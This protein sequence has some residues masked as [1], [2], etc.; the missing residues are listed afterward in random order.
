VGLIIAG[1]PLSGNEQPW[2]LH[3][4]TTE[5]G[6][7]RASAYSPRLERN[8]GVALVAI[9]HDRPDTTLSLA[10]PVGARD[11]QVRNLPLMR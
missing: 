7:L 4:D 10:T 9:P 2:P 5:V 1:D 8:V 6:T 3:R 11:C